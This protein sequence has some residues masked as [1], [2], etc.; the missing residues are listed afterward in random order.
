MR[1]G[2]QQQPNFD[3]MLRTFRNRVKRSGKLEKLREKEYYE[4]PAQR[5]QRL[6]NAAR[7]R[8]LRRQKEQAL[9]PLRGH[10]SNRRKK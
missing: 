8:E 7:R 3:R 9:R 1:R 6:K 4:K 10:Y 5:K 2:R